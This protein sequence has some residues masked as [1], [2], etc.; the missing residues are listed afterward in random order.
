MVEILDR[1]KNVESKIDNLTLKGNLPFGTSQSTSGYPTTTPVLV[2]SDAQESLAA[3][4]VPPTSP[5]TAHH[6]GG[7][8]YDSSV[9]KMLEWPAVRQMFESLGQK[10][11]SP[12]AEYALTSA[13]RGLQ[14]SNISLP[15]DGVQVIGIPSNN[16]LRVPL[17]LAGSQPGMNLNQPSIDWDTMQRLSKAYFDGFNFLY[18]I[19]DRQ[20]FNSSALPSIINEGFQEGA[21]S[22]L[23]L[24]VFALG[25]V[26]LTTSAVPI[27]AY[28]G[29]PSGVKGGTADRPPGITF[30]NEGRKRMGFGLS[31]ISLESVQMLALTSLYHLSCGQAI[32]SGLVRCFE[33]SILTLFPGMLED[34]GLG[35][36]GLPGAHNQVRPLI[37]L[38]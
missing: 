3:S 12:L 11:Q 5:T 35:L 30:F 2:E 31:E 26:A 9:A 29:R 33:P 25:E 10:P 17:Q 16:T 1:L 7:Y 18:P 37:Y 21:I 23:V 22:A 14:D 19:I 34:D 24:L 28:K 8:R 4:S 36:L 20:W 6:V 13:P 38:S 32:V 27:A 15:V